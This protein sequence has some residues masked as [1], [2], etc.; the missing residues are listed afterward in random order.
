MEK[1]PYAVPVATFEQTVAV[2]VSERR[3]MVG[4][5]PE[6]TPLSGDEA[7]ALRWSR[8][9]GYASGSDVGGDGDGD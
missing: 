4:L 3:E 7:A 5:P 2:P 6:S 9:D 1:N 8:G